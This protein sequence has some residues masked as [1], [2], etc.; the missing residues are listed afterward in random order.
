MPDLAFGA[1]TLL[2][3]RMLVAYT[4]YMSGLIGL[5]QVPSIIVGNEPLLSV[6]R[7]IMAAIPMFLVLGIWAR[8]S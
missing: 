7:Y 1:I 2:L 4:L 5:S 6:G 3:R 8:R